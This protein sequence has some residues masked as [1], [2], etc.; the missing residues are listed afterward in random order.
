MA[1]SLQHAVPLAWEMKHP[2]IFVV[3]C[4]HLW[5][6]NLGVYQHKNQVHT[7]QNLSPPGIYC[8][9]HSQHPSFLCLPSLNFTM[10]GRKK[11]TW[12]KVLPRVP[13]HEPCPTSWVSWV[14]NTNIQFGQALAWAVLFKLSYGWELTHSDVLSSPFEAFVQTNLPLLHFCC[15][16]LKG[17]LEQKIHG[18]KENCMGVQRLPALFFN[19]MSFQ[20]L[21]NM[22]PPLKGHILTPLPYIPGKVV[23]KKNSNLR[24]PHLPLSIWIGVQI[25]LALRCC[26][27]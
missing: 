5:K 11:R 10:S 14:A 1:E 2:I 4:V 24:C 22:L 17:S 3:T 9:P 6:L 25:G 20:V 13:D 21:L 8:M 12:D 16:Y 18:L 19:M 26:S 7:E 23:T 15:E 27:F